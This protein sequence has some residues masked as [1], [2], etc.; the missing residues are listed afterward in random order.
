MVLQPAHWEREWLISYAQCHSNDVDHVR[1][2]PFSYLP[3]EHGPPNETLINELWV[4][5]YL[6]NFW[7]LGELRIF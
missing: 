7:H 6:E 4:N 2:W 5:A 3:P 1:V